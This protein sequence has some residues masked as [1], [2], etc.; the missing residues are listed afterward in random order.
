MKLSKKKI[1][2]LLKQ[3]D[4]SRKKNGGKH[5]KNKHHKQSKLYK[6]SF[7]KRKPFNLRNKT[8]KK[9]NMV[10]GQDE[11][12]KE[13][14][15]NGTPDVNEVT[16]V[17]EEP[18]DLDETSPPVV[19]NLNAMRGDITKISDIDSPV[20]GD[21]TTIIND[22]NL[23][24]N[25]PIDEIA[26]GA[27]ITDGEETEGEVEGEDE[28]EG[29]SEIEG[30]TEG[31]DEPEGDSETEG[32][33][34]TEGEGE[35]ELEPEKQISDTVAQQD[36]I[37]TTQDSEDDISKK[38]TASIKSRS[39]PDVQTIMNTTEDENDKIFTIIIRVPKSAYVQYE[40]FGNSAEQVLG[41]LTNSRA[42]N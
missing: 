26:N 8:I 13:T 30:E 32:D 7:R 20:R 21:L 5:N 34:E 39:S 19:K 25:P 31:E 22:P 41:R 15:P 37:Q 42:N 40:E 9:K 10:G 33:G 14:E 38:T 17:N 35:G 29:D 28:S 6:K 4:Q 2:K 27:I 1:H 3:K 24:D 16:D 23:Q 36:L 12:H 11:D 18:E